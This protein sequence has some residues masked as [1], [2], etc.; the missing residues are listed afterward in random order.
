MSLE[1]D[2]PE[3][4]EIVLFREEG[5]MLVSAVYLADDETA[6][7]TEAFRLKV[8]TG[9][10]VTLESRFSIDIQKREYVMI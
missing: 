4:V 6:R 7:K 8:R 1:T 9:F 10:R 3:Q 2:A 5:R